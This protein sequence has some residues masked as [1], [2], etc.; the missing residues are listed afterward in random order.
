M[1]EKNNG[2][3]ASSK[4]EAVDPYLDSRP[5]GEQVEDMFDAIA[6][7]YDLMNTAMTF[8]LHHVWRDKALQTL[9]HSSPHEI[10]D[11][12]TGT[13]DVALRLHELYPDANI[14]GI[15]LSDGMLEIARRKIA[16]K[17]ELTEKIS[18]QWADCLDLPFDDNTFDAVTV[19]YGVRNFQRL[20]EGYKEML[21]V[22]KP[23][24]IICVIELSE[25][26]NTI[27]K[28]GYRLY[29][30]ILIPLIGRMVS[31]DSR[32]YTYLPESIAAC[33]QRNEMTA[34]IQ[35]AGF[36]NP[37]FQSLTLGVVTIY[38]AQKP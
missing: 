20:E 26:R 28:C 2:S 23:G 1:T 12:A 38:T 18:F 3:A 5:K 11:V 14:T 25:P 16:G 33:P 34:L 27:L 8:G 17:K 21:R 6:P 9:A 10:L 13:G 7:A 4:V 30:R 29:S 15:D 22:L 32:A 36:T 35:K 24:G 37:S 31:G 19:A